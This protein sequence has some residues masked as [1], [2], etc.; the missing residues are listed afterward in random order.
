MQIFKKYEVLETSMKQIEILY[1]Y[2][3]RVTAF[4][5][6]FV[7]C[8][9]FAFSQTYT[10]KG[11]IY[12]A[13]DKEP[14]MGATVLLLCSTSEGTVCDMKGNYTIQFRHK[15][16][17][18]RFQ[19]LGYETIIKTVSFENTNTITLDIPMQKSQT[20]LEVTS[21]N[22]KQNESIRKDESVSSIDVI[23]PKYIT[24]FNITSLDNAFNQTVGLVIVDNEPQMRGG[25]GFSS[26]M[27]SR[28]MVMMDEMPVM[29][30]DAGRPAWNLIPMENI[31]QIEV[32]KGA[33][34]VLYGSSATTGAINVRTTYPKGKPQ[35]KITL[36]NGFY[37]RPQEDYRCSWAKGTTP[38][39]YGA[40][41]SHSRRIK[42][43][44]LVF[45]AEYAH[46]DGFVN[47]DT[48]IVSQ[49]MP[50]AEYKIFMN[51]SS[52][53]QFDSNSYQKLVKEERL[54]FNFGTRYRLT[55]NTL[56]GLNGIV[57]YSNNTMTHFWAN[58]DNGMYNV[59]PSALST[60]RDFICLLDPHFK[61]FGKNES[62]HSVKGRY[63]YSD[64]YA[65]NNQDSRS[66]MY[67][68]EYQ[69]AKLF[70]RW[71]LQLFAG[72]VGQFVASDGNV[73]S[74]ISLLTNP[75]AK[76]QP[77]YSTNE[78]V[79]AQVEKKFLKKKNLTVLAGGRLE[80]SQICE[81]FKQ[82][83]QDDSG[84]NYVDV[85][86]VFRAGINYKID[87]TYTSF[88]A[89]FGQGYRFPTIG[90]RYLTIKVGNYGFYPNP[91]LQ[92][93]TSWN[94]E[95][96]INQLYRLWKIEGFIDIAAYY[97][98]YD[99]YVEFFMGPWLDPAL[100]PDHTK[101]YGFKFF[102]TGPAQIMGVDLSTAG[103]AKINKKFKASYYFAYAYCQPKVLDT[104][105][106]FTETISMV[107]KY[108]NTSSD[109]SNNIMKYRLEHVLKADISV[110]LFD[111]FSIGVSAQY[112]SLMKN[113]DRFFYT[114]D[115]YSSEAPRL[116]QG[117]RKSFPFDG[118]EEYRLTHNKGTTVM[119][120]YTSIEWNNLKLSLI[121]NNLFN[122]EY[123]LRPMCPEAPRLTTLQLM[124]KFTEGEPFFAKKKKG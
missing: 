41:I 28:V 1:A 50:P 88:R 19:Y 40:N 101:R 79:Y 98:R 62:V 74:G 24:D 72:A 13:E 6:F 112:Y 7:L 29:R 82:L 115:R 57:L 121:V 54:R 32:L 48:S 93:E 117:T 27:G 25:S 70:K 45:S 95:V 78:A 99:N 46:D 5:L 76:P 44:D 85:K 67:Y 11:R 83:R 102:N 16:C 55:D 49:T 65:P 116:I 43:F 77:K 4:L 108:N 35:T 58:A 122:K 61:H 111:C 110:T 21:I 68:L 39:S 66:K 96:G 103:E 90:E 73:F 123:S 37:S 94:V 71:D 60:M 91:D 109:V 20:T 51:D 2:R 113:V 15:D 104:T 31:E 34:S 38:L 8:S 114:M 17:E 56:L 59:Y 10:L 36:Y 105:Y 33:A 3:Q 89:S 81:K 120:I 84:G 23:K 64:N 53:F 63:M 119:G 12:D 9:F 47:M 106:I 87:S 86:P 69:Y 118:L 92:A 100:E 14:L 22:A 124:Y 80:Y 18:V 30:A 52:S 42:K 26:G 107:Y 75:D 97:Q